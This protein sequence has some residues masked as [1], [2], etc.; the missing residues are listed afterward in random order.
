[1]EKIP[2]RLR[3]REP[4]LVLVARR[5]PNLQ[6]SYRIPHFFIIR[7]FLS[8]MILSRLIPQEQQAIRLL[9]HQLGQR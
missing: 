6:Y 3:I 2:A 1:M 4:L 8:A 5:L 7:L 9:H